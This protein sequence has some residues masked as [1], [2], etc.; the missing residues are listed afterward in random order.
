VRRRGEGGRRVLGPLA[1]EPRVGHRLAR[2]PHGHDH[3]LA[4]ELGALCQGHDLLDL[5][6]RMVSEGDSP[7]ML[8]LAFFALAS[9]ALALSSA[10]SSW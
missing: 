6:C 10:T 5:K 4:P 1:L 2:G 8:S 9:R 3:G 7:H